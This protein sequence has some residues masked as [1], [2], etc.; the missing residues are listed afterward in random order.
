MKMSIEMEQARFIFDTGCMIHEHILK[1]QSRYLADTASS[2][3]S[4]L[5][6]AQ[7]NAISVVHK[8]GPLS[9]GVLAEQ[10]G[11]TAPSASAMVDRLVEKGIL[12]R[13]HSLEDRRKV[14]VRISPE[15][16]KAIEAVEESLFK[17]FRDLVQ[18]LGPETTRK[19]CDVL[20]T[21]RKILLDDDDYEFDMSV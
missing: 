8:N 10:L 3:G 19:W 17:L 20:A 16:V 14:E 11:I 1:A 12:L 2:L 15:A 6:V 18:R 5:S 7:M 13:E 9:M 21:I 4:E